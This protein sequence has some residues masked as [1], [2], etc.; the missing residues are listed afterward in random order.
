MLSRLTALLTCAAM[1]A[2]ADAPQVMDCDWQASA[3][4]IAE[5]WEANTRTFSNG[6]VRLALLD[7]IEPA[8]GWAYLLILSPPFDELGS[9]Q[10]RV[11]GTG[12]MGF[13]G[14]HFN[15]LQSDY[16]PAQGLIFTLPVSLYQNSGDMREVPLR[17][18]LNQATGQIE[19]WLLN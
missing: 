16:D 1:P 4:N 18:V 10:C 12:G 11:I 6:N 13:A 14:M 2:L 15:A 9:R 7:T 5:P 8:A 19:T 3:R 17:I